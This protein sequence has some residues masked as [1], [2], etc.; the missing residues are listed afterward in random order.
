[1]RTKRMGLYPEKSKIQLLN[2]DEKCAIIAPCGYSEDKITQSTVF[3]N[4]EYL[5]AES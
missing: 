3:E 5:N 4:K 1:M 2:F